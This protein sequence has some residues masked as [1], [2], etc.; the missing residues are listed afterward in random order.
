MYVTHMPL[1]LKYVEF[2][3]GSLCAT[4]T[5]MVDESLLLPHH[6]QSLNQKITTSKNDQ[7]WTTYA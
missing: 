6:N 3:L 1:L 4:P 2:G 5:F 7:W